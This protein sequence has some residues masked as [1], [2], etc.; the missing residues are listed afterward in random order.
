MTVTYFGL[1][2]YGVMLRLEKNILGVCRDFLDST[3]FFTTWQRLSI[4]P[5]T[6]TN[7]IELS[8]YDHPITHFSGLEQARKRLLRP[9]LSVME[10]DCIPKLSTFIYNTRKYC[11][12]PKTS[13]SKQASWVINI[14]LVNM[15]M[16]TLMD[17]LCV[18]LNFHVIN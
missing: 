11:S 12:L 7:H 6:A 14:F 4:F 10:L 9:G 1:E 15:I 5:L 16:F 13:R 2:T 3:L 8:I 18:E 17:S